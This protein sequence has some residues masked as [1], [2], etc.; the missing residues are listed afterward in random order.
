MQTELKAQ[1]QGQWYNLSHLLDGRTLESQERVQ[2]GNT[3]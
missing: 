2:V 1:L 3:I